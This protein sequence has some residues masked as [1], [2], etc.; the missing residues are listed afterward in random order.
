MEINIK[1]PLSKDS[2]LHKNV[3]DSIRRQQRVVNVFISLCLRG[4][5]SE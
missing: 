1:G 5:S 3:L 4:E 2:D